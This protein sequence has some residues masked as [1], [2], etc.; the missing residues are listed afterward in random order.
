MGTIKP[1]SCGGEGGRIPRGLGHFVTVVVSGTDGVSTRSLCPADGSLGSVL[2]GRLLA[3][4]PTD[5][6]LLAS[7]WDSLAVGVCLATV[8]YSQGCRRCQGSWPPL[9]LS[10]PAA[11]PHCPVQSWAAPSH[12]PAASGVPW[13]VPWDRGG[14]VPWRWHCCGRLL[15]LKEDSRRPAPAR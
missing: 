15:P 2:A 14:K 13:E 11:V 8:V 6:L 10:G 1:T 9:W 7:V 12:R 4:S 5:C 3:S